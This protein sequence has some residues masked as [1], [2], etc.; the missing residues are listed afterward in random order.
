MEA[1]IAPKKISL[2]HQ[3]EQAFL[4]MELVA[5]WEGRLNTNHLT[6]QL[7]ITRQSASRLINEYKTRYP[8]HLLYNASLK[9][10]EPTKKF[11]PEQGD[12]NFESYIALTKRQLG[13]NSI[14]QIGSGHQTPAPDIVRPILQAIKTRQR[15]DLAYASITSPEFE[16]RIISPH[17]LINDGHRWHVRAWCEK[18]QD[19]RDFV[20]TRIRSVFDIEGQSIYGEEQDERWNTWVTIAIEPA[21]RLDDARRRIVAMDYEMISDMSGNL[22]REYRIRVA[23]LIYW[24]QQLRV[25]RYRERPEA[26]QIILTAE[27]RQVVQR[28][29]P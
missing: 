12:G 3:Q 15:L 4:V 29:L 10:Y 9:C 21:P 28:W 26:Q 23:L 2:S 13:S 16:E 27:S 25:D 20:L 19:F 22:T 18:N 5:Q 8:D 1:P 14:L 11:R 6:Q 17:T 24:L 7:A